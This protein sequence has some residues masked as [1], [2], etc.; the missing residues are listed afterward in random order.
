M[1]VHASTVAFEQEG[2]AYAV[3]LAGAS[4]RGKSTLALELMATGARLVS[5]DQTLMHVENGTL[6]ATAP[7][8]IKGLIEWRG[9]GLVAAECLARAHV[10][11]WVDLDQEASVRLPEP[12]WKTVLGIRLPCLHIP[13]TA[14]AAAGL[15]QYMVAQ[16]WQTHGA[17]AR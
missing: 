4:G 10:A 5:D 16:A 14:S 17:F 13:A 7:E 2:A 15:R 1:A 6:V 11:V 3:V 12:S 9:I 8:A